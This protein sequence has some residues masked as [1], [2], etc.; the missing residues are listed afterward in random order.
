[1]KNN[2]VIDKKRDYLI[3]TFSRTKRKDY[4]NYIL[5]AIWHRLGRLDIKPVTQQYIKRSDGKYALIDLYFPQINY[6]I[7][8]DEAHHKNTEN[9]LKDLDRELS[10]EKMISS[11]SDIENKLIIKRVKAYEDINSIDKQI[12]YIVEEIKN[13]IKNTNIKKWE[14]DIPASDLA[15][16]NGYISVDDG[17]RYDKILDITKLAGKSYDGMQKCYFNINDEY[18]IWCPQLAISKDNK[19]QSAGKHGWINVLSNDW[20]TITEYNSD[21]K[22]KLENKIK[23]ESKKRI[24]FAKATNP[25]GKANYKF[26]G[27]YELD[28]QNS[29]EE[30][31]TYIRVKTK[32]DIKEMI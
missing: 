30:R 13:I 9:E 4:E 18:T 27:L 7:E 1:M 14:I 23:N 3:K 15:L 17:L 8:C 19:L 12:E 6:A 28:K 29:N 32:L 20:E 26:I 25:F 16:K 31:W 22:I 24:T 11:I 21:N 5:N 10:I 2:I